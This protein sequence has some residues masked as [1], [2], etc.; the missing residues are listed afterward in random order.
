MINYFFIFYLHLALP[1]YKVAMLDVEQPFVHNRTFRKYCEAFWQSIPHSFQLQES[2]PLLSI[3]SKKK[4]E[5]I[6]YKKII[7]SQFNRLMYING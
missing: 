6:I 4:K 2:L 5:N 3:H 7:N 1:L